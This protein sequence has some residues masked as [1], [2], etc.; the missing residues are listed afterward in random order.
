MKRYGKNSRVRDMIEVATEAAA[1]GVDLLRKHWGTTCSVS[2][3]GAVDLVTA[4]DLE[5]ED[6]LVR[7]LHESFPNHGIVAEER[8]PEA[9]AAE[10]CWYVDPLDGTT[11]FAHHYPHFAV[12]IALAHKST[13]VLGVVHDPLRD[14]VFAAVLGKGATLN[15]QRIGVSTTLTLDQGLLA[16]GFPYDRRERASFYLRLYEK[17]LT[18]SQGIRRAGSAALDL[19]YIAAG[20]L[21]G[22]WEYLLQPWD[23]AA[24]GLIVSEAGGTLSDFRGQQFRLG[25]E[26]ILASNGLIHPEMI[27]VLR[28]FEDDHSK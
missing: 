18:R 27:R 22:F 20:R 16:T 15:G 10:Y 6:L 2:Y 8:H 28:E 24:G 25:G 4:A 7:M 1:A 14:E 26:G 21:D 13:P 17:F 3:K 11:N 12:S 5:V 23:T 9:A 19:C